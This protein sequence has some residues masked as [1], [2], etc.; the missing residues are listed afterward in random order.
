MLTIDDFIGDI[1]ESKKF[2]LSDK[3]A[4]KN[5]I[6]VHIFLFYKHIKVECLKYCKEN[7]L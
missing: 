3:K 1:E 2:F 5:F 7:D 4:F 6:K